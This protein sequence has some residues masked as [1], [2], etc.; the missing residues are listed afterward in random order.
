[1][2]IT[3][4]G[5]PVLTGA[6]NVM[7]SMSWRPRLKTLLYPRLSRFTKSTRLV[8]PYP[9][10]GSVPALR[11]YKGNLNM[12]SIP[13]FQI[14][15]P[16]LIEKNG[17]WLARTEVEEDQTRTVLRFASDF[18]IRIVEA[19]DQLMFKRIL[20]A[21]STS[22]V[23]VTIPGA[24]PGYSGQYQYTLDG[25]PPFSTNHTD[26]YSGGQ[27]SNIVTSQ[28]PTTKA[29]FLALTPTQAVTAIQ[30][31]IQALIDAISSVKDTAGIQLYPNFDAGRSLV[32]L[33]P[34]FMEPA[35]C[36][37]AKR[38]ANGDQSF[39]NMTSN[40]FPS[41]VADVLTSGYLSGMIDPE[42]ESNQYITPLNQTDY[43]AFI[44]DDYV[45]PFMSQVFAP[46]GADDVFPR[47]YDVNAEIDKT[48]DAIGDRSPAAV[49]AS[50][51]YA[52]AII[53]MNLN[54]QGENADPEV[55]LRERFYIVPRLRYNV[56][57]G[58][59]FTM[60][61]MRPNGGN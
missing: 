55:A 61:R 57:Y 10:Y 2:P 53:D 32:I 4:L 14:S 31:D 42:S 34:K 27:V 1:M 18:G 6:A 56:G 39:V 38:P 46:P 40:V 26:Y 12:S 59:W 33:A 8:E 25:Q 45:Q 48:L 37:A 44:L 23:S 22:A 16:N 50:S 28:L 17:I 51:F 49:A 41:F 24:Q 54:K 5:D 43:Y 11:V 19:P 21:S 13:S 15:I 29:A 60:W 47:G 35:M 20:N 9:M 3:V 30:Q 7:M 58:P 52:S 36:L